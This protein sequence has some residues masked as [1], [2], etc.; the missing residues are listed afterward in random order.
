MKLFARL[1]ALEPIESG[2]SESGEWERRTIVV[3]TVGDER[4]LIALDCF[5]QR[6]VRELDRIEDG[7]LL[8]VTF[9]IEARQHEMRWYNRVNLVNIQP[10]A[11]EGAN[12]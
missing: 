9:T 10:Y 2:T 8:E 1:Y 6:R 12:T 3:E 5:G 11:K 4:K 7:Q